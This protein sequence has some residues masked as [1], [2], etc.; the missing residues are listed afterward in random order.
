MGKLIEGAGDGTGRSRID[1]FSFFFSYT[2]TARY[3]ATLV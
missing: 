3:Q 2:I 1:L